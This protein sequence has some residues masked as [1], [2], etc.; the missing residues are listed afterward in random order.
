MKVLGTVM[1]KSK[2]LNN[3]K[4][5]RDLSWKNNSKKLPW[6][7]K[8]HAIVYF[9]LQVLEFTGEILKCLY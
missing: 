8:S 7:T 6:G 2:V 9:I 3:A 4:E 5:T 1:Q